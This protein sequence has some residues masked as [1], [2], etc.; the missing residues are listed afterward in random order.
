MSGAAPAMA[1]QVESNRKAKEN[2]AITAESKT[3][4]SANAG[5]ACRYPP[6]GRTRFRFS[7]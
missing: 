4:R 2:N 1:E 3:A 5:I 6:L 7:P